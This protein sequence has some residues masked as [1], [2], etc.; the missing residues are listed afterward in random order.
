[1]A[2]GRKSALDKAR[3]ELAKAESVVAAWEERLAGRRDELD[4]VTAGAGDA[5][6]DADD[7]DADAHAGRVAEQLMR[8]RGE[9]DVAEQAITVAKHRRETAER[10]VK[11]A[12]AAELRRQAADLRSEA[13]SRQA[14]TDGLLAQLREHEGCEFAPKMREAYDDGQPLKYPIAFRTETEQLRSQ[15]DVLE[16]R[17]VALEAEAD[18]NEVIVPT[19]VIDGTPDYSRIVIRQPQDSPAA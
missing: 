4:R 14:R 18:G 8:L 3:D 9:I 7:G 1:M 2:L 11:R 16:G 13:D 19:S 6:L 15:A 10:G 12:E 17:A 5:V